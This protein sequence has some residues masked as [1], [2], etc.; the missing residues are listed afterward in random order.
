[1]LIFAPDAHIRFLSQ[2]LL[3]GNTFLYLNNSIASMA[4]Y[5]RLMQF[6]NVE[7]EQHGRYYKRNYKSICISNNS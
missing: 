7:V 1:M 2:F 6:K 3:V 5:M 4:K